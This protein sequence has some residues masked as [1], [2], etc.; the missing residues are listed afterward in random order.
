MTFSTCPDPDRPTAAPHGARARAPPQR[1]PERALGASASVRARKANRPE[2]AAA[3]RLQQTSAAAGRSGRRAPRSRPSPTTRGSR[4][5]AR[6]LRACRCTPRPR[7]QHP[8]GPLPFGPLSTS[9]AVVQFPPRKPVCPNH[10][11]KAAAVRTVAHHPRQPEHRSVYRSTAS[12]KCVL[13]TGSS[14]RAHCRVRSAS[15]GSIA[16]AQRPT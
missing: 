9:V 16:P 11:R 1:T 8:A 2:G 10:G 12:T 4:P 7:W 15:A 6:S 14:W 3:R 13:R 5:R